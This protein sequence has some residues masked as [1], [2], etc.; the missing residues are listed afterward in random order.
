VNQIRKVR[1]ARRK[2]TRER[3]RKAR[4]DRRAARKQ[5]SP[6]MGEA[7]RAG[8]ESSWHWPRDATVV[9]VEESGGRS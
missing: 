2:D 8:Q 6:Q 7:R 4:Q 9:V 1:E 3:K 5:A